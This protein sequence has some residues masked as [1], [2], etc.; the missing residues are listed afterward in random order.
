MTSAGSG[1]AHCAE[2]RGCV[3]PVASV[4]GCGLDTSVPLLGPNHVHPGQPIVEK[5][6]EEHT[7]EL[8]SRLHLVCRLLLEKKKQI[9]ELSVLADK[10]S[11]TIRSPK[12]FPRKTVQIS[13][14]HGLQLLLHVPPAG[15]M[16]SS[17][18]YLT[19]INH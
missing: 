9:P 12:I 5:R 14:R 2:D 3:R 7:S 19:L 15:H 13:T 1:T 17:G 10:P 18:Q 16:S 4:S 8:Q 6:S 11:Y